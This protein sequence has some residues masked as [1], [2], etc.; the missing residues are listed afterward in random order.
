VGVSEWL[1]TPPLRLAELRGKVV[2]VHFFTFG[3]INCV[4]NQ[5]AY[6]D[7]QE[8]FSDK[9]LVVLGI[10][11]PEAEHDRNVENVRQAI[12]EQG[13]EY[14]IA[15][16]EKKENWGAWANHTWPS[17]Y[18][19]DK[20]GFVRYWWYGELN[21]QG[22]QG[23]KL[24][25]RRI[26]ELLDEES[27]PTETARKGESRSPRQVSKPQDVSKTDAQWKKQLTRR[28]YSITRQ[29]GTEKAFTGAYWNCKK[30]GVYHCICCGVELF[31]S[32]TKFDSGTGWPS[33]WAPI[34]EKAVANRDDTSQGI[35]RV[36]VVCPQCDAHL[37]HV[38][39]DGPQPTGLRYCINSAALEL[40][41][42][43][44]P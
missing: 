6:C 13:L 27:P 12:R 11:T 15:V 35:R 30:T 37:G 38:F 10:H 24:F 3:C 34:H 23:E 41:E 17:V 9:G 19:I 36:E 22:A 42:T 18:L 8:R 31:G 2:A 26:A 40:E 39:T 20:E 16:D 28:Q 4:H 7:W 14:P 32:D 1:N 5:P 21:W 29:K 25:A 33:F 44:T 43:R